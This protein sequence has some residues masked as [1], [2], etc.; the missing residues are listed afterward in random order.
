MPDDDPIVEDFL[1]QRREK[2]AKGWESQIINAHRG[3][4]L[5]EG[6]ARWGSVQVAAADFK[7]PLFPTLA[8]REKDQLPFHQNVFRHDTAEYL[9]RRMV[10]D[11]NQSIEQGAWVSLHWGGREGS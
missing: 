9:S 8:A 2:P 3:K 10:T 4:W 11:E 5:I 1:Q 6:G 7:S